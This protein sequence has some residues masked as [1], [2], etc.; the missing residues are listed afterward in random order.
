[1]GN[2]RLGRNISVAT[3]SW[4]LGWLLT[5][6]ILAFSFTGCS[7]AD[8]PKTETAPLLVAQSEQ[9]EPAVE[10]PP[11]ELTEVKEAVK[12]VFKDS[13]E[14]DSHRK[15]IF[16]E[17]D[18]NGDG[19]RDL[20]VV[21]RPALDKLANLNEEFPNWILKDPFSDDEPRIPRLRVAADDTLLAVIH[22][23]GSSGWRDSQATQTFLL[24]NAVGSGMKA[25]Q[26]KKLTGANEANKT[27]YLRGDVIGQVVDGTSGY[28]YFAGATY[29]WYDPRTFQAETETGMAHLRRKK[30]AK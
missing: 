17:G 1:M 30:N 4:K 13:V 19:S 14:I 8:K 22:G 15:P 6:P 27:P 24:K 9:A 21:I 25:H 23:Y 20:A 29:S 18:F 5:I 10:L 2:V 16:I 26:A 11:P 3:N 12:R 7:T 28:L